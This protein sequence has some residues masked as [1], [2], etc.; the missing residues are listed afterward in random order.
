MSTDT[1]DRPF[2]GLSDEELADEIRHYQAELLKR[3]HPQ[4]V[5]MDAED[6]ALLKLEASIRL[7]GGDA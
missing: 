1:F 5:A 4:K 7:T 6:L 2:A 3:S